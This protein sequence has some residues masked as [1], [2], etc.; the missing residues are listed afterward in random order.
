MTSGAATYLALLTFLLL[1]TVDAQTHR[2]TGD[3][4]HQLSF[5]LSSRDS[6]LLLPHRFI[7]VGSE[8]V[9]RDSLAPLVRGRDYRLESAKG[10]LILTPS[11]LQTLKDDSTHLTLSVSYR[12][13]PLALRDEYTLRTVVKQTDS[14]GEVT[15]TVVPVTAKPFRVEDLFDPGLQKSGSIVRGFSVGSTQDFTLNSGF[16]M[17]LAGKL[18]PNI[19]ILAAL[20]DENSPIQPE[21][22]TQT[23]QEVDKVFVELSG[24]SYGAT[25]GDFNLQVGER[26]GG[27]FGRL[28]RKL[29]GARATWR[30][31]A[32][33]LGRTTGKVSIAGATARGKFTTNQFQGRDGN[34]GPYR[35]TS[36]EGDR[37]MIVL[38][39]TERVYLNGERMTRGEINDYTIDYASAEVTFTS[40]RLITSA[41]RIVVDFEY[42][43][44]KFT[45]NLVGVSAENSFLQNQLHFQFQALQEADD[46]DA[47]LDFQYEDS[48]RAIAARSGSNR[49]QASV[50]G[51]RY[52]GI[53]STTGLPRGQY[54]LRDTLIDSRPVTVLIYAPG[55]PRSVYAASFSYV[56]QVPSDSAGYTR[57]AIGQYVFAGLGKGNYLPIQFLPIPERQRLATAKLQGMVTSDLSVAAEFALSEY[58]RNRFS[59]LDDGEGKGGAYKVEVAYRPRSVAWGGINLGDLDFTLLER[60]IGRTFVPLDRSNE[61]EFNRKW[62]VDVLTGQDEW[63]REVSL[64]YAPLQTLRLMGTYGLMRRESD[65][66]SDRWSFNAFLRDSSL[67]TI[68]YDVERI[69]TSATREGFCTSWLRQRGDLRKSFGSLVPGIRFEQEERRRDDK[70]QTRQVDGGFRFV[71]VAPRLEFASNNLFAAT[72]ELQFRTEDSVANGAMRRA[73]RSVTQLYGWQLQEWHTLRSSLS[74]SIRSVVFTDE[75]KRR[76]SGDVESVLL[77]W[78]TRFSPLKKGVDGDIIYEAANQRSAQLERVFVRVPKGTGNY[79]YKGDVNKNGIAEE[80]E[81]EQTRFEGDYILLLLPGDALVPVLDVKVGGRIRISPARFLAHP[82]TFAERALAALNLETIVR[83]EER[84]TEQD[85]QQL[86]FLNFARFLNDATTITG[87]QLVGQDLHLYEHDPDFSLRLRFRER[88]NLVKLVGTTEKGYFRERS[89]RVRTQLARE[90]GNQTELTNLRDRVDAS[91]VSRRARDLT[92]IGISTE[93]SYRPEPIWEITFGTGVTHLLDSYG[94]GRATAD[95]NE[96]MIR[97]TYAI[98]GSGQLRGELKREEVQTSHVDARRAGELPFEFTQGRAIGRS[99]LWQLACDY[100]IGQN[101]QVTFNYFGRSEGGGSPIHTARA[102]AKAFF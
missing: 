96:Q 2:A 102:E 75:F 6:I 40:K 46:P 82:A 61:V 52:V 42:S 64:A 85:A 58:D 20:T 53:D 59:K 43:D 21:G 87:S 26:E 95:I 16:R 54:Y 34:Q 60:R 55:D 70:K 47:P 11:F 57:V 97:L 88:R 80:Y 45:R 14:L 83:V 19:D 74:L 18:A 56:E 89:V 90:I 7:V 15:R 51:V 13:L 68:Q 67:P 36:R 33:M 32:E 1:C 63:I 69:S 48:T 29:Q 12:Y 50:S 66:R 92:S 24:P 28:F 49:I 73:F 100:R 71:E 78:Q 39:G 94:G 38:A 30:Y 65:F 41:S 84:S 98:T 77:R 101:V 22:T 99:L 86:Y 23:L 44:R 3:P 31:E 10:R 5:I 93:F 79:R 8:A 62:D 35:L 9:M 37:R 17:Q 25:I 91:S 81:F 72:A 27:E 76:G 4:S